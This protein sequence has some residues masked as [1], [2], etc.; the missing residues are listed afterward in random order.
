MSDINQSV[1]SSDQALRKAEDVEDEVHSIVE[2]LPN[3][4]NRMKNIRV[5]VSELNSGTGI[6]DSQCKQQ[7]LNFH[8]LLTIFL[9]YFFTVK[10]AKENIPLS[11]AITGSLEDLKP[12][13]FFTTNAFHKCFNKL[14]KT[15]LY[16]FLF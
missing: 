6:S 11:N 5:T 2:A 16:C 10:Q 8:K 15:K 7:K 9:I 13:E 4:S 3:H 1:R 12:G 14:N